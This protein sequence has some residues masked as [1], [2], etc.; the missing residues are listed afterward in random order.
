MTGKAKY[1]LDVEQLISD[2][3]T[4]ASISFAEGDPAFEWSQS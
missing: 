3:A 2:I 1:L 4:L